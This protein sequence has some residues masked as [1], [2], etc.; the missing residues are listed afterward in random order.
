[1]SDKLWPEGTGRILLAEVDSTNAE[2]FR[3]APQLAGP[4]WILAASQSAGRGRRARPWASPRG[5][6]YATHVM[7]SAEPPQQLALRSF[8]AALALHEALTAVTGTPQALALKWPNDVLLSGGKVAGILLE[9]QTAGTQVAGQGMQTLAIGIGVNLIGHPDPAL[10]EAGAT[11][12]ASVLT[13]TGQRLTPEAFLDQLGPAYA[14]WE[15][16][17][18]T[19]GFAPIRSAWLAHAARLGEPIRARTGTEDRHGIFDSID[20]SG[21]LILRTAQATLAIP[22]AEVFF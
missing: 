22:A 5:N 20:A 3:Q 21:N 1:M 14:R 2:A 15:G 19:Q 17:F 9:C 11:P 4:A 6:F 12:P 10:V 18:T 16:V 13:E 7:Q 8:V